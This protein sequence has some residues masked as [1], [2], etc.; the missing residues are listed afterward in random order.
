[1]AT[2][3]VSIAAAV[4]MSTPAQLSLADMSVGPPIA[5]MVVGVLLLAGC[6]A[7]A[8]A[9]W[10]YAAERRRVRRCRSEQPSHP[11]PEAPTTGLHPPASRDVETVDQPRSPF[12]L[13]TRRE[14]RM[15]TQIERLRKEAP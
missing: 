2:I 8:G 6:V 9:G 15:T 11:T 5:G 10:W 14:H 13:R 7:G 1:M 4:A 3:K 12:H